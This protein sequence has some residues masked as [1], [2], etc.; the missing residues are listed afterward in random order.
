MY[1]P[2]IVY[3]EISRMNDGSNNKK[4]RDPSVS[5]AIGSG[6]PRLPA[7]RQAGETSKSGLLEEG[8]PAG[9]AEG[10]FLRVSVP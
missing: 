7:Y 9:T 2:N 1:Q 5:D 10:T 4:K 3:F 6:R 8:Q